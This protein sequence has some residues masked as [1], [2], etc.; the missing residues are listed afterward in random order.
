MTQMKLSM[1]NKQT[2]REQTYGCQGEK[3]RVGVWD[4]QMQSIMYRMDRQ[5]GPTVEHTELYSIPYSKPQWK[6]T[7]KACVCVYIYI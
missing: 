5:Q 3:G 7:W 1:K 6:R 4:E 2:H